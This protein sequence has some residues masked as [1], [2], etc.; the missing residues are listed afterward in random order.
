VIIEVKTHLALTDEEMEMLLA[1]AE[2]GAIRLQHAPNGLPEIV[3]DWERMPGEFRP[4][5]WEFGG[6]GRDHMSRISDICEQVILP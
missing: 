2:M 6:S 5:A 4:R 3:I 1:T